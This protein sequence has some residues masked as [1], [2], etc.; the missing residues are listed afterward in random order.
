MATSVSDLQTRIARRLGENSATNDTNESARRLDFI[1]EAYRNVLGD[2]YWWFLQTIASTTTVANQEIYTISSDFR[3]MIELRVDHKM[4]QPI[5]QADAFS[6]YNYPP[7]YYQYRS[8]TQKFY[9]YGDSELHLIPVPSAAPSSI[10]V[11]GITRS[12]DTATVTTSSAHGYQVGYYVTIAGADQSDYNGA[13]RVE[14]VPSTTTFTI[15]V[16]NSPTT[17][18]TG[19]ITSTERNIVYRYWQTV[20]NL[21]SS[22]TSIVIPDRY[23]DALVYGALMVK[24]E[25]EGLE[26]SSDKMAEKYTQIVRDMTREN[27]RKKFA[28]KAVTPLDPGTVII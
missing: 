18:A 11:S 24:F 16:E 22:S 7:L 2:K 9:I 15:T 21:T 8:L 26:G 20:S 1:N 17:P 13:F 10:S 27:N 25:V 6:T 28:W 5:S 23:A 4:A 14:S 12:S 19:T 3:D